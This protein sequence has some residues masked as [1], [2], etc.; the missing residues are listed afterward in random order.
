MHPLRN[1]CGISSDLNDDA[2]ESQRERSY[3]D[4]QYRLRHLQEDV[5]IE[6][7]ALGEI[8]RDH[9]GQ[10]TGPTKVLSKQTHAPFS[11]RLGRIPKVILRL[12][13]NCPDGGAG[14]T[15]SR[16]IHVHDS[17]RG[18]PWLVYGK[19]LPLDSILSRTSCHRVQTLSIATPELTI[20]KRRN[21]SFQESDTSIWMLYPTF[22]SARVALAP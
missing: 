8:E 13:H 4:Y 9:Q 15:G 18:A 17:I 1:R 12:E 20:S 5:R 21:V 6:K 2:G 11:V 22:P 3:T 14:G 19:S 7:A 16:S 10:L